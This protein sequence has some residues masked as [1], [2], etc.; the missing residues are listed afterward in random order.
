MLRKGYAHPTDPSPGPLRRTAPNRGASC[1]AK[2]RGKH[3]A[4]TLH[5][6]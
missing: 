5:V 2:A 1:I 6:H 3:N 4:R